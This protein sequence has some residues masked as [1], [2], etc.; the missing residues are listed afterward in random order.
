MEW[1]TNPEIWI[2]LVTLT[3][4]EII[5]GI[6]NIIFISILS[7]KLPEAEQDK[8][9]RVGLSLAL[10]MRLLLLASVYWL[11]HLKNPLFTLF[12]AEISI[13]DLI[14][15]CGG[16][17]LL[18]K[19]TYEIHGTL[20]TDEGEK[21]TRKASSFG[22]VIFQILVLDLVFSLDS[23]IT[24]I[25]VAE[26]FAVMAVAVILAV[27]FMLWCARMVSDFVHRHPTIKMLALSFLLL[28]GIAL[29]ADGLDMH[30]P[31]GYLYFA[32]GFS[33]FVEVLNMKLRGGKKTQANGAVVS[34]DA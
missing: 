12:S 28:I 11:A 21:G 24:A 33:F 27:I 17:F 15:I 22:N 20:E 9:R 31:K 19:S 26:D 25:G 2:A 1:I 8:A 4:L 10:F 13:R 34:G 30:I 29:V 16:L 14:L 3:I 18:A 6:D 5:L 32:M 7:G 23:V